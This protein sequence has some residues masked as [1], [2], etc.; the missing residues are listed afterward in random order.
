MGQML[1]GTSTR[2]YDG[3][4]DELSGGMGL[5][6][7]SVS[8]AF[9]RASKGALDEVNARDLGQYSF[10]AIMVDGVGFADRTVVAVRCRPSGYHLVTKT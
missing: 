2:D 6:K 1:A 5:S 3:V 7:S 4:L 10:A 9:I 8:S